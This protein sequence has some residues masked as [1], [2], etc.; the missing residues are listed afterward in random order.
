VD[1]FAQFAECVG[2]SLGLVR[3][4]FATH[5]EPC[6]AGGRCE[7]SECGMTVATG[8]T[9]PK[10]ACHNDDCDFGIELRASIFVQN[11]GIAL[12]NSEFTWD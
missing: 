3:K 5:L 6:R 1:L 2:L 7:R 8:D 9:G 12:L 4:Q 11:T 10:R